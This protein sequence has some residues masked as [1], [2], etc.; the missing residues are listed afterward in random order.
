MTRADLE[1]FVQAYKQGEINKRVESERFKKFSYEELMARD[2]TNLDIIWLKDDSVINPEDLP[3]PDVIAEEILE[4][5]ENAMEEIRG[6][7]SSLR[8]PD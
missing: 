4:N 8:K 7:L 1:E 6:L 3:A 5:L 2:K